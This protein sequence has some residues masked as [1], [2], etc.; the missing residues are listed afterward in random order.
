MMRGVIQQR[1]KQT[2]DILEF[3]SCIGPLNLLVDPFEFLPGQ[4]AR[5]V[6]SFG[7]RRLGRLRG[8]FTR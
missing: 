3:P 6:R 7:F 8:Q 5:A 4:Y 2:Q 1:L